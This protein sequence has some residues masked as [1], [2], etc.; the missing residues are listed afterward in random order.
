[1]VSQNTLA[2][3]ER[4]DFIFGGHDHFTVQRAS[5][6]TNADPKVAQLHSD[7][8]TGL[9]ITEFGGDVRIIKSGTDWR[10]LSILNAIIQ[11]GPDGRASTK[12]RRK[13][14]VKPQNFD[15]KWIICSLTLSILV[16][17]IPDLSCMSQYTGIPP[18]PKLLE[19]QVATH[20]RI[21]IVVERA[22][23]Y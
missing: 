13:G 10:G 1:M 3:D 16:K 18:Y 17:Q 22:L 5:H 9:P 7:D 2:G 12:V 6:E 19:I 4:V 23:E 21:E 11:R 14:E 20:A 15:K 8:N